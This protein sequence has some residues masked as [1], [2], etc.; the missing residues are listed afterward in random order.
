MLAEL[1]IRNF[2]IID[3]VRIRFGSGLNVLT[4]ET[5]AGKSIILDAMALVLGHRADTSMVRGGSAQA[6]IEA[7]FE[8]S[9][10]LFSEIGK[11]LTAEGL[12]NGQD[13]W[14][15]LA[16]EV[17]ITGRNI[18]RVNGRAVSLAFLNQLGDRLVDI[19]GQ[20][21]HL[22]LL[23][24]RTHLPLLDAYSLLETKR[25][26]FSEMVDDLNRLRGELDNLRRNERALLQR[27]DLL[28]FQVQEIESASL[29]LDEEVTLRAE[30]NRLSNVEQLIQFTRSSLAFL[31]GHEDEATSII[32]MMGQS[33]REIIRL[34]RLD[35]DRNALLE[36]YQDLGYRLNDIISELLDYQDKLD[37]DPGRLNYIEGRLEL[38]SRL[39]RKYGGDVSLV[40]E[41]LS[42]AKV[43]LEGITHSEERIEELTRQENA[44]LKKAGA[45]AQL[46]SSQRQESSLKL[47][48]AI[49]H[50]L[51][52]LKMERAR[53][54]VEFSR[55]TDNDGVFVD[56]DRFRFD[57]TGIDK[58]EFLVSANPGEEEKPLAKV[59]SGGE[60]SRLMLALKTVLAS[61]DSTP[62]LIFDEIDQGIGGQVGDIV[63]RKLWRLTADSRHQVI[64]VTHLPQLSGYAD[65]HFHVS[66]HIAQGRTVT[67]VKELVH[68]ERIEELVFMLGTRGEYVTG[69]AK[70]IISQVEDVKKRQD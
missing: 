51:N 10:D 6:Q 45:L 11:L 64:V 49:E 55:S 5:G 12:E 25:F 21:D 52:D 65:T 8:L 28:N 44:L 54:R 42:L 36:Q 63:G 43:E 33:E 32:N 2:A 17:R 46:L 26:A 53:F 22:S 4:G 66:K 59:A 1:Y 13:R 31:T 40:L 68:D 27:A 56:G 14:L 3:E 37:F 69:T 9:T 50:E 18:C 47:S 23:K 38:I 67:A 62:T 61:A 24:P 60:T 48:T 15:I 39:K 29:S 16:R 19:H 57:E 30:R 34:A 20:G 58:L 70:S 35:P 41:R 7:S